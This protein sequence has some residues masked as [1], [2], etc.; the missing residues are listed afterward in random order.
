MSQE[1]DCGSDRQ[2]IDADERAPLSRSRSGEGLESVIQHLREHRD[3]KA[4]ER[5]HEGDSLDGSQ[6]A[7]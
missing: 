4:R 1:S 3:D 7:R 2:A 5:L 6:P